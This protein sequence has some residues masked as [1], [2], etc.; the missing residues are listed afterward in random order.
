MCSRV[1]VAPGVSKAERVGMCLHVGW[2]GIG[3]QPVGRAL[4][5]PSRQ[6]EQL[7]CRTELDEW[8]W[9]VRRGLLSAHRERGGTLK[10]ALLDGTNTPKPFCSFSLEPRK[11]AMLSAAIRGKR[12]SRLAGSHRLMAKIEC[13]SK[14]RGY[15]VY[16]M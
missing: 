8:Q 9:R 12:E 7:G 14:V 3:K 2:Q 13:Q 4:G 5:S 11:C 6:T 16:K 15:Q 10:S 1:P